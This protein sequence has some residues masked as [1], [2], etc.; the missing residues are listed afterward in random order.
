MNMDIM[1]HLLEVSDG[2]V[3]RAKDAAYKK[4]RESPS[5]FGYIWNDGM[6]R[7]YN[8]EHARG[9]NAGTIKPKRVYTDNQRAGLWKKHEKLKKVTDKWEKKGQYFQDA[10]HNRE[11]KAWEA[12]RVINDAAHQVEMKKRIRAT[13][14]KTGLIAGGALAAGVG[15]ALLYKRM[16]NKKVQEAAS[17]SD[18]PTI[19]GPTPMDQ[20]PAGSAQRAQNLKRMARKRK[21]IHL[22]TRE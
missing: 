13:N 21:K 8:E 12:Q 22:K 4:A 11:R 19:A 17:S 7:V 15:G 20:R 3:T 10:L 1:M 16:K 14:I 9:I 18:L 2:L 5:N 6:R